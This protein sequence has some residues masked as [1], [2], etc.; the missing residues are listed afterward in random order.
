VVCADL[1][2]RQACGKES[3]F[4]HMRRLVDRKEA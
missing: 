4:E 1:I 3:V 2:V